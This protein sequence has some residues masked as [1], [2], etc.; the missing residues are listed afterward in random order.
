[1]RGWLLGAVVLVGLPGAAHAQLARQ[2][3]VELAAAITGRVC[4]D[5][6]G[7]GRC[8]PDEPGLADIR[9][10]L[11][12]GREVRTDA[13][14]R[15]HFAQVDA[16]SPDATG[17]VHL[18]PGRQ[19]LRVD[20]RTLPPD[21]HAVPEA[22]TLDIPWA[23]GVL[24]D[25]AVQTR[26]APPPALTLG[27]DA[28]PPAAR[29]LPDGVDF[30]LAGR[31]APREEVTVAG[32][33]AEVDAE[34]A[35]RARVRLVPGEN[36]LALSVLGTDGALRLFR[37]RVDVVSR[38]GGWLVVP[39]APEPRGTLRL[40]GNQDTPPATG[41][42]SAI[43][44]FPVGTR[45]RSPRGE[46]TVGAEG[47]ALL[48][49]LL[50][51]GSN[52]I[53]LE[54]QP[55]GEPVWSVTVPREAVS[56]DF[57]VGL[58][59]VEATLSPATGNFR[60]RGRGSA[61]GEAHLGPFSVV[62]EL[63]LRD[64]D[65]DTLRGRPP[66]DALRPQVPRLDRVPDPDLAIP[67]WGDTSVGLTP[68][69]TESRLRLE[70]RHERLGRVGLGTYRAVRE[71]GEVG[72]YHRPLF[73]PYAE[74]A[75]ELGRVRAGVKAYAGGLSDPL[76]AI[77][78]MPAY[79]ELRAT[80]G[81]LYYLGAS[82]MAEGS[83]LVRVELR[84]GLTGLP[85]AE[86]HLVRGRDY[87]IDYVAGRI[88]L[89]KPL[90][91]LAGE[92]LLRTEPLTASPEPVLCVE[93]A[94]LRSGSPA[95]AVGGEA[96]AEWKG[97]RVSVAAVREPSGGKA[98]QLLSGNARTRLGA[99]TLLAEVARSEGSAVLP[100]S[101]G[102]SDDGGLSFL[103]PD[104]RGRMDGGDALGL[105]L[106]GPGL[107]GQGSVDAAFRRR[108]AGF[109]DNAH[110]DTQDF[111]QVSLRAVQPWGPWRLTLL[112][113][114]RRS[115]DP[116]VP[117]A[118]VPFEARTLGVGLDYTR[119]RWGA[120]VEMRAT[121]LLATE[122]P[123]TGEPLA[124]GRAS[125]GLHGHYQLNERLRLLAS[126]RQALGVW[127]QGPGEVDDTFSAAGADVTLAEAVVGVRG[128]WGP[129]LGPLAWVQGHW[130][131]GEDIYYGG[132]SV[133]VDG[134]DF[135]AGRAV[136]GASTSLGDG[137]SVFVEDVASHDTQAV[138]L[139]RAVGFQRT[140]FGA[141][142]LGARYERGVRN[143]LG[144]RDPL[145]RDVAGVSGQLVL[146]R[147]R[148][149]GHVELR[150]DRGTPGRGSSTPVDR[151]QAVTMLSAEAVLR[152]DLSVS[153][154]L[155]HGG[156]YEGAAHRL[157]AR[158]LEGYAALAW[159]PGPFML[160]ARYGVTRELLPGERSVFGER[161]QQII[162]LLPAVHLTERFDLA[163]GM[164]VSRSNRGAVAI[165]V[166]TGSLR[167]SMR[168]VGGLEVA[169]EGA[170]RS[171]S[172]DDESLGSLRGEVAYRV[173]ERL[174]V[175]AGYTLLG[176]TGTGLPQE[177]QNASDRL[178]LRAELAY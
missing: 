70:A 28:S 41:P 23:S 85:L 8:A 111:L 143:V 175:A 47:S 54:V 144:E 66:L 53:T 82:P 16:R 142:T 50:V 63:D 103:R 31:A 157:E 12:S 117:F 167:P 130:K 178:Y 20:A 38:E 97:G 30:L 74:L 116:R 169:V 105:R 13:R 166:V 52:S 161:A 94:V 22:V 135:G 177:T 4:R 147:L 112:G 173:N 64:T 76:R 10:V 91:F 96:W 165:W 138:R 104:A 71:D 137:T 7:D 29:V 34:G 93:Y 109:S 18:R 115:A 106:R 100:E 125:L 108:T 124:G 11:A 120:G 79:E 51:P 42:S 140:V 60:L 149:N 90:S 3:P 150:F 86:R 78:S 25:F 126:H 6:D 33:A 122:V 43:A 176:F 98:Y 5:L 27:Y 113:D 160:V 127:G 99:Y 158:L 133:D 155:N 26:S 61:H 73:G 134:P 2:E 57:A 118:S 32:V 121:R 171:V 153:G 39:R 80:G 159:R 162:S 35:W 77:A 145:R 170:A 40:P 81:S 84:D 89:A 1:M 172:T 68:N 129:T 139:A 45:V 174:R 24:R 59:D 152:E 83:E 9:L 114:E 88:L 128:G 102:V 148:V 56:R 14:G 110:A 163:A 95:D 146:E 107:F 101:F 164:H 72:R 151:V 141:M 17:G 21:S 75:A 119:E 48:P 44:E 123:G 65:W 136:S 46:V 36:A 62:G 92:P 156:T 15:Y 49:L 168:V 55:P 67:E 87:D 69:P 19:R 132:Y 131:R 58:L 154:R 37:Q